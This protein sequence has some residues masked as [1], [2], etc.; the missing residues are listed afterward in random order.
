MARVA[1]PP[2]GRPVVS[3][4]YSHVDGLADALTVLEKQYGRVQCETLETELSE[5]NYRE[6]MG[7]NL[8]RRFFSFER[9]IERDQLVKMKFFCQKV[10]KQMGDVVQ[11]FAFRTVNL[12]PGIL[13]PDN[14]VMASTRE[15]N[16]RI[17]LSEGVFAE[18]TLVHARGRFVRLPWTQEDY[19]K[20]EAIEFFERVR[21]SMLPAEEFSNSVQI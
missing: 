18:L 13:T 11:D 1:K 5:N 8:L 20:G 7:D 16:H 15:Y 10:E 4:I 9:L 6:E 21:S 12:D 3:A 14:L 19:C 17:Y 2:K